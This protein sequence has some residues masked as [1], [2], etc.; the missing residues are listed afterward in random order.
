MRRL[1]H[2]A[3]AMTRTVAKAMKNGKSRKTHSNRVVTRS[4]SPSATS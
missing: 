1:V 4:I 3:F 2:H